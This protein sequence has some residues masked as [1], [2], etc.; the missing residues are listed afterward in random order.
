MLGDPPSTLKGGKN[1][2]FGFCD[3]PTAINLLQD[4]D[5]LGLMKLG[6]LYGQLR[7]E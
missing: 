6:L 2:R 7:M 4:R 3:A 5:D 1:G